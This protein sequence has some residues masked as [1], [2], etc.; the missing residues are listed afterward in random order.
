MKTIEK[1]RERLDDAAKNG[2]AADVHY[3][4]GY[5][6]ATEQALKAQQGEPV[7]QEIKE[8]IKDLDYLHDKLEDKPLGVRVGAISA[9]T[10]LLRTHPDAQPNE[11]LTLEELLEMDG[12][13]V[14]V[15]CGPGYECRWALVQCFAKSTKILFLNLPNGIILHPEVEIENGTKIYR[16]PPKEE[17]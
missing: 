13:P 14:W 16:R 12:E 17:Q 9:A 8:I 6:T 5:L 10:A 2:T 1:V 11:P 15:E 4:R 3:W 7:K